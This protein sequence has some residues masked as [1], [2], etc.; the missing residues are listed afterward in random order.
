[1]SESAGECVGEWLSELVSRLVGKKSVWVSRA[2][3]SAGVSI[4]MIVKL[5]GYLAAF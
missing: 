1:M 3:F 2:P 4:A 5:R